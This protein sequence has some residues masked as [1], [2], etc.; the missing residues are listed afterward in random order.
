MPPTDPRIQGCTSS[1]V[2]QLMRRLAQHYD[3]EVAQSGIKTTQYAL[4]ARIAE[5]GPM[6]P[7]DLAQVL[8]M[9]PSTLS[10]NLQPLAAAGWI[11]IAPGEDARSHHVS[12]TPAGRA[13]R[14]EARQ[15]WRV[16][17]RALNARVGAGRVA[18][19]HE[20]I[21]EMLDLL[22]RDPVDGADGEAADCAAGMEH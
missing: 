11:E 6:R 17:Q 22:G 7:V 20:L 4:L 5:R 14:D 1:K 9:T 2:R 21:D 16:A 18:A 15:H 12:I 10:R 8:K 13:K 3:A 19:L